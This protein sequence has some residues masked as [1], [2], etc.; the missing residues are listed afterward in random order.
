M[1]LDTGFLGCNFMAFET[2]KTETISEQIELLTLN[3]PNVLNAISSK[4]AEEL[5]SY[6]SNLASKNLRVIIVTGEGEKAF[7]AGADLKERANKT[8]SELETQRV[9]FQDFASAMENLPI[10]I[11]AAVN[12]IAYGGGC[13]IALLCDFI[14]ASK[15]A[16]FA[17]PEVKRGLIPGLGGTQRLSRRI[18]IGK[19]KELIFTGKAIS[20]DEA[21]SFGLANH[22]VDNNK[23]IE[24]SISIAKE[25]VENA[26]LAV[27]EAKKAINKGY[28]LKLE[29]GLNIES[30]SYKAASRT[31]DRKEGIKAFNEKRKP[32]W[33]GK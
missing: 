17:L 11:I 22:I 31:E 5:K 28:N 2:I 18:G 9:L 14:I 13:E 33:S 1:I 10:P 32:Q 6:F 3:R 4:M 26:P 30:H 23:L 25:I 16:S 21:F 27:I 12:G 7:C 19:A 20:A 15:N 8:D 24:K 29:E